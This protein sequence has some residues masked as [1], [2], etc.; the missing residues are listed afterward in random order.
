MP[1]KP[2]KSNKK[3]QN[4][5]TDSP[6]LASNNLS[7]AGIAS[8]LEDHRRALSADFKSA[9]STLEAKLDRI[10]A[11]VSDCVR[12]CQTVSGNCLPGQI[13]ASLES[14]A[15][16]Q[17]EL[18]LEATCATLTDSNVKLLAKV[19][20]LES[21]SRRNNIRI[22]GLSES[23]EGPHPSTFFPKLLMEVLGEGVLNSPPECDRAHRSLTDK[24]KPGQRPRP[25]IIRVHRYQQKETIIHEARARRGKLQYKG[26]PIAIYEDYTPEVMEQRYK[27]REV[28][29]VE[30]YNLGLKP[31]LHAP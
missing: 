16:L 14:N 10:Q 29:V 3:E 26:T 21:C 6:E 18:A 30:L 22:V 5:R 20:D 11:T 9:I 15:N 1:S 27:Y 4:A 2:A 8:L 13:I 19:T 17:D 25:V 24:P 7:M 31:A 12:L 28:M 23:I